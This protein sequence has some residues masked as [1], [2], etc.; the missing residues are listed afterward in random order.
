[1]SLADASAFYD[2]G[3]QRWINRD[4]IGEVGAINL[5]EFVESSPNNDVDA[6]G[7]FSVNGKTVSVEECEIVIVY[8]HQDPNN[9]W[10]FK[11][12]EGKPCAGGAVVCWPKRSNE[13]IPKRNQIP[14]PTHDEFIVWNEGTSGKAKAEQELNPKPL[15]KTEFK[16]TIDKAKKKAQEMVDSDQCKEVAIRFHRAGLGVL[17]DNGIPELP[18]DIKVNTKTPSKTGSKGSKPK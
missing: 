12:P 14:A 16:E 18:S 5:F 10:K 6:V 13:N 11:F 2:P 7:L 1:M 8:G 17:W 3:L 9:P 15:G 4:P